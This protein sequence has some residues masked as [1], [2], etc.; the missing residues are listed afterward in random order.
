[1]AENVVTTEEM[2]LEEAFAT[3]GISPVEKPWMVLAGFELAW[4]GNPPDR[5]NLILAK[6]LVMRHLVSE[7]MKKQ[8]YFEITSPFDH[9]CISCKGAGEIY[10]FNRKPVEVNCH[11]CAGKK[12]IRV[13][14]RKCDGSGRYIVRDKKFGGGMNLKCT[15]CKGTGKVR[16]K[17]SNCFGKGKLKKIVPDHSIK[18]TTPCKHCNELGFI[19]PRPKKVKKS[20][21]T[22]PLSNPVIPLDKAA[23]LA[24]IIKQS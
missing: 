23:A 13:K 4:K 24:D 20:H 14:C 22:P 11:I 8:R 16:V 7:Q 9:S 6:N 5:K 12:K 21:T 1:M 10:K 18:S 15:T 3:V 19:L 17:C 2:T